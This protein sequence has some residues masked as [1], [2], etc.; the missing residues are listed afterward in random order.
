MSA[1]HLE[2]G[3]GVARR[4]IRHSFQTL[5]EGGCVQK[6]PWHDPA[7]R[8]GLMLYLPT[9]KGLA[10]LAEGEGLTPMQC[11]RGHGLTLGRVHRLMNAMPWFYGLRTFVMRLHEAARKEGHQVALFKEAPLFKF[12][13]SGHIKRFRA[14]AFLVYRAKDVAYPLI[15][16][17]DAGYLPVED[18]AGQVGALYALD[19]ASDS[20]SGWPVGSLSRAVV[21]T[22]RWRLLEWQKL[23]RRAEWKEHSRPIQEYLA[24]RNE[25]LS[26]SAGDLWRIFHPVWH[27][28]IGG[29]VRL[30]QGA[31]P[32]LWEQPRPPIEEATSSARTGADSR[33][34]GLGKLLATQPDG[35]RNPT[36]KPSDRDLALVNLSMERLAK[37]I[38]LWIGD[39]PLL[40]EA[41]LAKFLSIDRKLVRRYVVQL[42][43]MGLLAEV[44]AQSSG[45]PSLALTARGLGWFMRRRRDRHPIIDQRRWEGEVRHLLGRL[46]HTHAVHQAMLLLHKRKET[47]AGSQEGLYLWE[48]D[49]RKARRYVYRGRNYVFDPD[50]FGIYRIGERGHPFYL[51]VDRGTVRGKVLARKVRAYYS[52]RTSRMFTELGFEF[53]ALLVV[54]TGKRRVGS[55]LKAFDKMGSLFIGPSLPLFVTTFDELR[56][57]GP[58]AVIW[59]TPNHVPLVAWPLVNPRVAALGG[60]SRSPGDVS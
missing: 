24:V 25:L 36:D 22:D 18:F 57:P 37:K 1:H 50:A 54:T 29:R 2:L 20:P 48:S 53:P 14:D 15:L 46:D 9:D 17:W 43:G 52:W 21:T 6:L 33:R 13:Q 39:H 42:I 49:F 44:G 41:D 51:E 4:A 56:E 23:L 19:T 8:K 47:G 58:R 34:V 28:A 38:L 55:L 32:V 40:R 11:A 31:R 45:G 10:R 16:F 5:V 30:L 7:L 12:Y 27:D 26:Q 60:D 3:L 35:F 59:R